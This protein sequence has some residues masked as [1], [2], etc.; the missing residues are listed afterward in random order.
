MLLF[1]AVARGQSPTQQELND[2]LDALNDLIDSWNTE[3]QYI[4]EISRESF[5]LTSGR[6]P[7]TIGLAVGPAGVNGD[8]AV[9]RP[10]YIEGASV[11]QDEASTEYPIDVISRAQWQGIP[12]KNT[13]SSYPHALWYEREFPLG[14]IWLYPSPA[15]A[16]RLT[17]Y[18]WKQLDS[19][20][21]LA[22]E[23]VL[24][25]AYARAIR[26]NLAV[27]MAPEFGRR[28]EPDVARIAR[29][30]KAQ[31]ARLNSAAEKRF[32]DGDNGLS[33]NRGEY[34]IEAGDWWG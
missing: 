27:E 16:V 18:V 8:L 29:A 26:F 21:T 31:I 30:S 25:P 24:P 11:Q 2:G 28:P 3:R 6:N 32:M 34:S 1:G 33:S 13:G 19:G 4:Y 12:Y 14:K 23:F 15:G 5:D 17:L 20:M 22:S 9:V 10:P 7:H